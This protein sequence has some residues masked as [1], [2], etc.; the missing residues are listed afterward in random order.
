[1][2]YSIAQKSVLAASC[3]P[4][5]LFML[6]L[7][8]ICH[9]SCNESCWL[10]LKCAVEKA[11]LLSNLCLGKV[12][13]RRIEKGT[14]F[15]VCPDRTHCIDAPSCSRINHEKY[16]KPLCQ[17]MLPY[18]YMYTIYFVYACL[19]YAKSI[20]FISLCRDL[21]VLKMCHVK[22]PSMVKNTGIDRGRLTA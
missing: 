6:T 12:A 11:V 20:Q 3:L 10:F 16:T 13:L 14:M 5:L 18:L 15:G 1:M 19:I 22:M 21:D 9:G 7:T 4:W 17:Q 8:S 2:E